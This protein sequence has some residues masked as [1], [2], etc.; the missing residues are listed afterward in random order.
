MTDNNS[1]DINSYT[2]I[3]IN[4]H[5]GYPT[6]ENICSSMNKGETYET[7]FQ[8]PEDIIIVDYIPPNTC[9]V[10]NFETDTYLMHLIKFTSNHEFITGDILNKVTA[11][12]NTTDL[13]IDY[14][15][16]NL[17]ILNT[18]IYFPGDYYTNLIINFENNDNKNVW[19]ISLL[20]NYI[21]ENDGELN[22]FNDEIVNKYQEAQ[23]EC[24]N[25]KD[26]ISFFHKKLK[27][28]RNSS[29]IVNELQFY[30][31][32]KLIIYLNS[33][34][35]S[36]DE[37][38]EVIDNIMEIDR[39]GKNNTR[40]YRQKFSNNILE[41]TDRITRNNIQRLTRNKLPDKYQ[42]DQKN[43]LKIA[44]SKQKTKKDEKTKKGG[45]LVT[46]IKNKKNKKSKKS[47]KMI[48]Y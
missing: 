31:A 24:I 35:S 23:N 19:G 26:L 32:R 43:K 29:Q 40:A 47:K 34:R 46:K 25:L 45:K 8:I 6:I 10:P 30:G 21:Q 41:P 18:K 16:I 37:N 38:T 33:C 4:S 44:K 11:V 27:E 3:F 7:I 17:F 39:I 9:P 5:A 1:I 42:E 36:P 22:I 28:K 20:N 13:N 12:N 15:L 48:V 14:N 2:P